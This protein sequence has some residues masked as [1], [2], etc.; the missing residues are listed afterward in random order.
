MGTRIAAALTNALGLCVAA[1]LLGQGVKEG[2]DVLGQHLK[3]GQAANGE[4]VK[5]GLRSIANDK[6]PPSKEKKHSWFLIF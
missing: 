4:C 3:D 6:A 2:A 5:A 1:H